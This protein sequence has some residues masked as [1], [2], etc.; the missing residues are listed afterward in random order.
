MA[1]TELSRG[2]HD[3]KGDK[4]ASDMRLRSSSHTSDA[5]HGISQGIEKVQ[6]VLNQTLRP[7]SVTGQ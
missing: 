1:L 4:Y 5:L 3:R 6:L 7:V 2:Q